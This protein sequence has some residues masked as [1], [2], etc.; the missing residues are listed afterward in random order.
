MPA[1][2]DGSGST[3]QIERVSPTHL[4]EGVPWLKGSRWL[5]RQSGQ[6]LSIW[7]WRPAESVPQ[8]VMK[9][10][11]DSS[12]IAKIF[13]LSKEEIKHGH[14]CNDSGCG[15][16]KMETGNKYVETCDS[17]RAEERARWGR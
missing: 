13:E 10:R 5:S 8:S 14:H 11:V 15:M 17:E 7:G 1:F 4:F 6:N 3:F 2:L 16:G 9:P 12:C